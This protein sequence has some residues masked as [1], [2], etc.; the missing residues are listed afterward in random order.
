MPDNKPSKIN[1]PT[2]REKN[3]KL[4]VKD[5]SELKKKDDSLFLYVI[6]GIL[7]AVMFIVLFL[8]EA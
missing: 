6:G 3:V 4:D 8:S 7:I 5:E 1:V 2:F